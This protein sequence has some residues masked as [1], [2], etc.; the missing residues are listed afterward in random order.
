MKSERYKCV[1]C[2]RKKF[3]L[4]PANYADKDLGYSVAKRLPQVQ[5][6]FAEWS[7]C[8]IDGG[9]SLPNGIVCGSFKKLPKHFPGH[10]PNFQVL[11]SGA[12]SQPVS[13]RR[14]RSPAR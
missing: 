5:F 10:F 14:L 2:R 8:T 9:G 11:L 12:Q 13:E 1:G 3:T 4:T 7:G 6:R